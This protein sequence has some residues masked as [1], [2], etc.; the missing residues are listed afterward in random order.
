MLISVA[1]LCYSIVLLLADMWE[2]FFLSAFIYLLNKLPEPS[3]SLSEALLLGGAELRSLKMKISELGQG[4]SLSL[5][6]VLTGLWLN[7]G[8]FLYSRLRKAQCKRNRIGSGMNTWNFFFHDFCDTVRLCKQLLEDSVVK[9][10]SSVYLG[11][12]HLDSSA[13]DCELPG[14]SSRMWI[15]L[16]HICSGNRLKGL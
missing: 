15:C 13:S 11:C 3:H 5:G 9:V 4:L 14:F 8:L 1:P 2:S 10:T 16:V 12:I 6:L 7:T